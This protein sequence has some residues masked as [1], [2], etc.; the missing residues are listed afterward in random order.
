[1]FFRPCAVTAEKLVVI[2]IQHR[3]VVQFVPGGGGVIAVFW[4][5]HA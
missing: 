3:N 5:H 2:E 4:H 1:M